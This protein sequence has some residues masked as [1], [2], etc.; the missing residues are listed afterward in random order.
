M[1]TYGFIWGQNWAHTFAFSK[2]IWRTN[3]YFK[4]KSSSTTTRFFSVYINL[5]LKLITLHLVDSESQRVF[6]KKW[7][8]YLN[9]CKTLKKNLLCWEVNS[10]AYYL[11]LL[12]KEQCCKQ[13]NSYSLF[14]NNKIIHGYFSKHFSFCKASVTLTYTDIQRQMFLMGRHMDFMIL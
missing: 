6:Q 4:F 5:I 9:K 7:K 12:H 11:E 2:Q 1:H 8:L 10:F 14:T 13:Q 3:S